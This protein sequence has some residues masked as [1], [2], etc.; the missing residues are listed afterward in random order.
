MSVAFVV[1]VVVVVVVS[2]LTLARRGDVTRL[3]KPEDAEVRRR[4][5]PQVP[6]H[7]S[8]ISKASSY[9]DHLG[10]R[11]TGSKTPPR[12]RGTQNESTVV[13]RGSRL[14]APR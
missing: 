2:F 14:A 6:S 10:L 13:P 9:S 5:L 1:V 7:P 11:T 3:M 12:R 4:S 8:G